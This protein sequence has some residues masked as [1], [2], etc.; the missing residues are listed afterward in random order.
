VT[1]P[2]R[3]RTAAVP[4]LMVENAPGAIG[5]YTRA[6]GA[7]ELF[8][9]TH[10]DGRVLHAELTIGGSVVMVGD[11]AD[12][13]TTPSKAGATV[14]VHVFVDDVDALCAEA[15]TAGATVLQPAT[16]MFYGARTVMLEDPYGHVWVF[17]T[18]LEDVPIEEIVR[19]GTHLLASP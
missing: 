3:Y 11:A 13:F 8:R 2:D 10:P 4:H 14:G 9:I 5:F 6:F 12:G 1:V 15:V 16:D 7:E 19:R 18:P 17:L